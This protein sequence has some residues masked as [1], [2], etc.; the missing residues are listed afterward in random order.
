MNDDY[1]FH[2]K[3]PAGQTANLNFDWT[4][5]PIQKYTV[6]MA[7]I[8][9]QASNGNGYIGGLVLA[10]NLFDGVNNTEIPNPTVTPSGIGSTFLITQAYMPQGV[11]GAQVNR[12]F[13]NYIPFIITGLPR[14]EF[15]I[16]Y[17]ATRS[18]MVSLIPNQYIPAGTLSLRFVPLNSP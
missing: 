8:S 3:L 16:S 12:K 10:T 5:L 2:L 14:R 11:S 4:I 18:Q 6:F 7:Y 9:D 13:I 17:L 15:K 1:T